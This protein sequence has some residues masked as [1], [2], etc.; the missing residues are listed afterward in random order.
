MWLCNRA[1]ENNRLHPTNREGQ[2]LLSVLFGLVE[3]WN[4]IHDM[5]PRFLLTFHEK[6]KLE[7]YKQAVLYPYVELNRLGMSRGQPLFNIIPKLHL[8]DEM[9]T[10]A[11]RTGISPALVWTFGSEDAMNL[12]ARLSGKCHGATVQCA[13]IDRW[14]IAFWAH[15]FS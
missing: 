7:T 11:C 10:T 14:L 6:Q 13:A 1:R 5:R 2:M 8:F 4:L 15:H 3:F 9:L 12:Y